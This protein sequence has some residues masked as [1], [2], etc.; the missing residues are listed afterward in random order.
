MGRKGA[1]GTAPMIVVRLRDEIEQLVKALDDETLSAP[2]RRRI[3]NLVRELVLQLERLLLR[4]D[5]V[6]QPSAIFD[7]A[8]PKL[9]GRFAALANDCTGPRTA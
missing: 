6:R 1:G 4:L 7:P 3:E 8:N 5:P 9:F 2:A